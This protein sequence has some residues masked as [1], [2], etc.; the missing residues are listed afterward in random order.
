MLDTVEHRTVRDTTH[1]VV[2]LTLGGEAEMSSGKYHS[3]RHFRFC[4]YVCVY[5]HGGE[6]EEWGDVQG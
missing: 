3:H 6:L 1:I 5:L 4:V 2:G